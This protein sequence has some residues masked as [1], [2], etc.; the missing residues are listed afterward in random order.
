M[1]RHAGSQVDIMGMT[2]K[3]WKKYEDDIKT[4]A[5]GQC[6]VRQTSTIVKT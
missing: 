2:L 1:I 6:D 5:A 3:G 4:A